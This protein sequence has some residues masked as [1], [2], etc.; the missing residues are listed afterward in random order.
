MRVSSRMM[1]DSIIKNI[2]QNEQKLFGAQKK[3]AT[4]KKLTA[5]SE[6]PVMM[7]R[8]LGFNKTLSMIDQ[9]QE[10]ITLGKSRFQIIETTLESVDELLHVAKNVASDLAL[11]NIDPETRANSLQ[12][13]ENVYNQ[14]LDLANTQDDG[15]YIFAGHQ[16]KT[17]PYTRDVDYNATYNGDSGDV[18][19]IIGQNQDISLNN[20]GEKAFEVTGDDEILNIIRDLREGIDTDNN[21]LIAGQVSR[22]TEAIEHVRGVRISGSAKFDNLKRADDKMIKLKNTIETLKSNITDANMNEAVIEL[23]AQ[24]TAYEVS[25]ASSAKIMQT[26]LLNFL[27]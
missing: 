9:Y 6:N 11:E 14:I 22:L 19:L 13:I 25:L 4:G 21:T 15:Q 7:G 20:E 26:N 5:A 24:E 27:R 16:T 10:N 1:L 18:R 23:K 2:N 12:A 3:V 17:A 8:V